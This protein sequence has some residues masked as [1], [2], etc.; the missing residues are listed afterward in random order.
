MPKQYNDM[1]IPEIRSA[2]RQICRRCEDFPT[3]QQAE[4]EVI[5]LIQTELGYSGPPAVTSTSTNYGPV[6]MRMF[7]V[8]LKGPRGN[9]IHV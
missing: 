6:A 7:M 3:D 1:T 5:R 9:I 8:M 4:L 2:V